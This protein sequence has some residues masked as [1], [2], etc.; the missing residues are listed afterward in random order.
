MRTLYLSDSA[1]VLFA[2]H[3]FGQGAEK[4][5]GFGWQRAL[6]GRQLL[7]S[8]SKAQVPCD[9]HRWG[10]RLRPP[11][12]L[13][14]QVTPAPGCPVGLALVGGRFKQQET[15][16]PSGR[17]PP[18]HTHPVRVPGP[19]PVD[20]DGQGRSLSADTALSQRQ[21]R[22]TKYRTLREVA[23]TV[24]RDRCAHRFAYASAGQRDLGQSGKWGPARGPVPRG[25]APSHPPTDSSL[26]C[27]LLSRRSRAG[28]LGRGLL[29][30]QETVKVP[31]LGFGRRAERGRTPTRARARAR[32]RAAGTLVLQRRRPPLLVP[33]GRH[34]PPGAVGTLQRKARD[35]A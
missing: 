6:S 15:W 30:K 31:F 22:R 21:T 20:G 23:T 8:K 29:S 11:W 35:P 5:L 34:S 32:V 13:C 27:V 25:P 26:G 10:W 12:Y 16:R 14:A 1:K 17:I 28:L 3:G 18:T 19:C 7:A 2:S 9:F 33:E 4:A 24:R